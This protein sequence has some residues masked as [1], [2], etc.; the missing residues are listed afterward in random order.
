M[1]MGGWAHCAGCSFVATDEHLLAVCRYAEAPTRLGWG[2]RSCCFVRLSSHAG[3]VA[4]HRSGLWP[5]S[6]AKQCR[7]T[8]ETSTGNPSPGCPVV[9][10]KTTAPASAAMTRLHCIDGCTRGRW[11]A[12]GR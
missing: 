3:P 5:A 7:P 10:C 2:P 6:V 4:T 9:T 12:L 11:P 1:R 8:G